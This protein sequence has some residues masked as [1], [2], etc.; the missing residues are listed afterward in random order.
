M[1][2]N[3]AFMNE[4]DETLQIFFAESEDLLRSA[5]DSLLRLEQDPGPGQDVEELFRAIH[6]LKSGSAMVGFPIISDY[7]HVL[8]NLLERVRS[9]QLPISKPLI[10]FLLTDVD[11][12]RQMVDRGGRGEP[13]AAPEIIRSR[14]AQL[15]R[16]LGMTA[17]PSEESEAVSEPPPPKA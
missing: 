4:Q 6:T 13:E 15:N 9:G 3:A 1:F 8:E 11:F 14:K 7:S 17:I 2:S 12:L 10:T 16:F 5:E